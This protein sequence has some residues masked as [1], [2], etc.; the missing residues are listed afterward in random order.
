[1]AAPRNRRHILVATPPEA[2]G[3]TSRR[4][5]R[6]KAFNR[7]PDRVEQAQRLTHGL[8]AAVEEVNARRAAEGAAAPTDVGILV[9]F[10]APAGVDLKLESLENKYAGIELRGVRRTRAAEGEPYVETATVFIPEGSV[11]HFLTRFQQYATETTQKGRPKNRELVDRIAAIRL[12]TLRAL[13]TDDADEFPPE[14]TSV[15]WEVWLRRDANEPGAEIH[16]LENF[17]TTGNLALGLRRLAF[18]DRTVCLIRATAAQLSAS[19]DV[20]SDLAELRGAKL[21][22]AFFVDLTPAEQAGRADDLLGRLTPASA[23]APAVCLFDTGVTREHP[24]VAPGLAAEDATAVN[25]VWGSHDNGGGPGQ[26]GHG[27]EMAGLA[28]Y[29]DLGRLLSTAD[30]VPLRHRLESVKILP[31]T[32]TN[33]PDLYGAIT[34]QATSRPEIQAPFRRRVFS[35]AITAPADGGRGQPTSWSAA[36]DSLAAGRSFDANSDGLVYL[37]QAD[38]EAHRL[39]VL[40]AGNVAQ[41][42][43]RADHLAVCDIEPVHDPAHAWNALTVGACTQRAVI[44]DADYNGWTPIANPGDLSPWSSTGVTMASRWP[45]KPDVVFEGGNVATD[46]ETFDGGIPD[47]CLLSTFYRPLEKLFVLTNATSAAT[48]QVA[49]IAAMISADYPSLWP[50]TL[51]ALVVHSA[52]WTPVMRAAIDGAN[53][54]Q[55]VAAVLHR[56]GFGSPALSRALR[57]ANDA[58]TLVSQAVIHPYVHGKTREMHLHRLPWP[59]AALQE[60]ADNDVT[61][62]VTLSYFVEPN[63]ARRGWR[64]RHRYA[65]HGLR[66]DVKTGD[67]SIAEFRRR[68]NKQAVAE[69]GEIPTTASD[70]DEW[71][72]GDQLRHRGSLHSDIWEGSAAVLA[73]RGVIG[74]YPVSGWWKEQPSRDRSALGARYA[75]IVSIRTAVEG[76]DIWTPV[77]QQIGVPVQDIQIEW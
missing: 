35:M 48:A 64:A 52:E 75:L 23:D 45:N 72:L 56:Y 16:R 68:L 29:G 59:R 74:V 43:L 42:K 57:S 36:V 38:R 2:E 13:W 53:G 50:E 18:D 65:S 77:A 25:P 7:P 47:L 63:P 10:Q 4:T 60:L 12:A 26:A 37:D 11:G 44:E 71:I 46:G 22:S 34:A 24:L 6:A 8:T 61:L 1:M 20:L 5:G 33:D 14:G 40:A 19:L 55:A 62:R 17:A 31:P 30:A 73:D 58:L 66:F 15:W 21:G 28:L 32:G 9:E 3:F 76:V 39:F 69:D 67:E 27:T 54:R 41:A 51:R 49:R 70:S